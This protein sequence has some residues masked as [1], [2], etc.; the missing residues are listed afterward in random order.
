MRFHAELVN[1]AETAA[2]INAM[3]KLMMD[4]AEDALDRGGEWVTY[5]ARDRV[6]TFSRGM[7]LKH[8]PG[9]ITS[10][11]AR[12]RDRLSMFVGP[13]SK[14]LQGKMGPGVELGSVNTAPMPHL[15]G[16]FDDRI[17]AILDRIA[18]AAASVLQ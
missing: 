2:A 17:D 16:A 13:E 5:E 4:F 6:R 12:Y 9:S 7:Y 3:P 14:R 1:V 15:H 8:Y 10:E 18:S 11:T